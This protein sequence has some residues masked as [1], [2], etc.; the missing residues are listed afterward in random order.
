MC[1]SQRLSFARFPTDPSASRLTVSPDDCAG[2]VEAHDLLHI[3]AMLLLLWQDD[4]HIAIPEWLRWG[5]LN[6]FT[7]CWTGI[8]FQDTRMHLITSSRFF[9]DFP[10]WSLKILNTM[11]PSIGLHQI[12]YNK[13]YYP[14]KRTSCRSLWCFFRNGWIWFWYE[15]QGLFLLVSTNKET[16][17]TLLSQ[18][19]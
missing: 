6:T 4:W 8:V 19:G 10:G 2:W 12:H 3:L 17:Y 7:I 11:G 13:P 9:L 14:Y 18:R 5:P 1:S 16:R 15:D